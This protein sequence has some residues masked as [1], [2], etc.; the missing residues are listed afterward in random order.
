MKTFPFRHPG[1]LTN[2]TYL[3]GSPRWTQAT[4]LLQA[5]LTCNCG[6]AEP[7]TLTLMANGVATSLTVVIR[8]VVVAESINTIFP[9]LYRAAA[10]AELRWV[11]TDGPGDV[12]HLALT[13][14]AAE[15]GVSIAPA[16]DL[17]VQWVDGPEKLR[18]YDYESATHAFTEHVAGLAASRALLENATEFNAVIQAEDVMRMTSGGVLQMNLLYCYGGTGALEQVPRLEFMAGTRRLATLTQTGTLYVPDFTEEASVTG[19]SDRFEL[20][21]GSALA[22]VLGGNG[23]N[24]RAVELDEPL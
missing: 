2:G 8:P 18:L 24:L 3:Q 7:T 22:A 21:G 19:G 14:V 9:L 1:P 4:D 6:V 16:T 20:Y 12:T 11:V 10:L 13:L 23:V 5:R 15:V 17:W